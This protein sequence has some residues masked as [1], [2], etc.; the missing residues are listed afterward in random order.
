MA[1]SGELPGSFGAGQTAPNDRN[2]RRHTA[3]A[4]G[5]GATSHSLAHLMHRL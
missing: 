1:A 2:S 5:V 4:S 3:T